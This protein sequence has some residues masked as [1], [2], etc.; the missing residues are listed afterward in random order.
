M[1][2]GFTLIELLIAMAIFLVIAAGTVL[3]FLFYLNTYSFS[4]EESKAIGLAQQGLTTMVREIR[5]ARIGESGAWPIEIAQDN[6]FTFYSD[7][8]NDGRSD[9]VRYFIEGT[10][11]KKAVIQPTEVPVEYPLANE[12]ITIIASKIDNN[13]IPLFTYFN[14]DY[15]ADTVNNPLIDT[16]RQLNTRYVKIYLRVDVDPESQTEA[17]EIES[18]V[19]IRSMKNNL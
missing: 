4:L 19:A 2:K 10:D 6:T 12:F 13:T 3:F 8:T 11:L 7:V 5:E 14:G 15:P 16:E 17:F 1:T 18:G 9:R